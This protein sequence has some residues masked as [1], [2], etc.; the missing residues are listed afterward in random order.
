MPSLYPTASPAVG[1]HDPIARRSAAALA[2]RGARFLISA[3][4]PFARQPAGR[5]RHRRRRVQRL[6]AGELR[7][8]GF[9]VTIVEARNDR[10]ARDRRDF[11]PGKIVRRRRADQIEPP[12]VDCL[13]RS[14][15]ALVP[16]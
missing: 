8:A 4:M 11:V 9:D 16:R 2:R 12:G 10:R 14:L 15:Q 13:S 5:R 3:R 7:A 1:P 6:A